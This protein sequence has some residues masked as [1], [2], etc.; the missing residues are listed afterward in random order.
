MIFRLFL[1]YLKN[2]STNDEADSKLI[3]EFTRLYVNFL[4]F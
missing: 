3:F 2:L 1:L 4:D